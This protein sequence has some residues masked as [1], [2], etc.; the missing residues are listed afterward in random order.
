MRHLNHHPATDDMVIEFFQIDH[1][2]A[3]CRGQS[4]RR[5]HVVESQFQRNIQARTS[6]GRHYETSRIFRKF[7]PVPVPQKTKKE[8]GSPG[9]FWLILTGLVLTCLILAALRALALLR[10]TGLRTLALL[11]MLALLLSSLLTTLLLVLTARRILLMRLIVVLIGHEKFLA[12]MIQPIFVTHASPL[13]SCER[14]F[15]TGKFGT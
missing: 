8:P 14:I 6:L 10:A 3:G 5:R 4:C 13:R 1:L 12:L 11:T 9:S 2:T 15:E 7:R